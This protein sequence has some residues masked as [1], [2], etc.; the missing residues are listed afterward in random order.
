MRAALEAVEGAISSAFQLRDEARRHYAKYFATKGRL[1]A[2]LGRFED[3]VSAVEQG[4]DLE[5]PSLD[6]YSLR[7]GEYHDI[8]ER[9]LFRWYLTRVRQ[10]LDDAEKR[11]QEDLRQ[12]KGNVV[13]LMGLLAAVIAFLVG[14][15]PRYCG[16]RATPCG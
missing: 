14:A 1:L 6:D 4:V 8:R 11:I 13:E 3:A 7:L 15:G 12:L 16:R 10:R 5:N 9:V 2:L